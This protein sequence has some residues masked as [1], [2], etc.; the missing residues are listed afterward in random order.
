MGFYACPRG[1]A[2]TSLLMVTT[3][4][5][6]EPIPFMLTLVVMRS[7]ALERSCLCLCGVEAYSIGIIPFFAG[8]I[9]YP[10]G[11]TVTPERR[12]S[13]LHETTSYPS[14]AI[15]TFAGRVIL[16]RCHRHTRVALLC[17]SRDGVVLTWST[18]STSKLFVGTD[19]A[20]IGYLGVC[21]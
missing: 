10:S 13:I 11:A 7:V 1:L 17:F 4:L 12:R 20:A 18:T 15:L 9:S 2:V 16:E 14:D 8:M 5:S 19:V 21:Y 3:L 6:S